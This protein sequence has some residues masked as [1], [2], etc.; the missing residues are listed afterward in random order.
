LNVKE[1][2]KQQH[3]SQIATFDE[4]LD[5]YF[6]ITDIGDDALLCELWRDAQIDDNKFSLNAVG[7]YGRKTLHPYSDIDICILYCGY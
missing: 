7:G 3:Q 6:S 1:S 4:Q 5:L 2:F